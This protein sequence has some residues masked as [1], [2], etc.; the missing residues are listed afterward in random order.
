MA[1]HFTSCIV[2]LAVR[3][4]P[5][6]TI[7]HWRRLCPFNLG[8]GGVSAH[9]TRDRAGLFWEVHLIAPRFSRRRVIVESKDASSLHRLQQPGRSGR[10]DALDRGRPDTPVRIEN[11]MQW[12]GRVRMVSRLYHLSGTAPAGLQPDLCSPAAPNVRGR[13]VADQG[14][15][16]SDSERSP[17]NLGHLPRPCI[18]H[19]LFHC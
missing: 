18:P 15:S 8:P 7:S 2:A 6:Q 11:P 1:P 16:S 10:H 19:I 12:A 9:L 17:P 3:G 14:Y 4:T 13:A 5:P